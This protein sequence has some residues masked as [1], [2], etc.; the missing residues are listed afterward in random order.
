MEIHSAVLELLQ[1]DRGANT[2]VFATFRCERAE[3]WSEASFRS[4][5]CEGGN[6]GL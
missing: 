4:M 1:K 2:R 3:N 6:P 5:E